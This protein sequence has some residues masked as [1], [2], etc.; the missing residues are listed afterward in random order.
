MTTTA[1]ALT[2]AG[3]AAAILYAVTRTQKG[4]AV[5]VDAIARVIEGG[6][7]VL[8]AVL[9]RGIRNNNP[10]NIEY[11]SDPARAWRG[12]VATDGRF[13][14][15]DTIA[16]GVRALG[17]QLLKYDE[18]GLSTVR[19]IIS[20]WAPGHENDT[21]AYVSAVAREIGVSPNERLDVRAAL[22]RLAGA[23]IRH[24]NGQ[25]PFTERELTA[26]VY[27]T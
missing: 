15:Y 5:T 8:N 14:V 1:K 19:E 17:K 2:A 4:Q 7:A 12:Q 13:G 25:Q 11:I 3:I 27:L 26:W 18:R 24:E 10:G 23:I 20:T 6:E 22:P 21:A 9:P 16:N